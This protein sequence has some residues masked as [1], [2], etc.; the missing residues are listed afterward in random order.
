MSRWSCEANQ[1]GPPL[2]NEG[3]TRTRAT[4]CRHRSTWVFFQPIFNSTENFCLTKTVGIGN[5]WFHQSPSHVPLPDSL[6]IW[7]CTIY[8]ERYIVYLTSSAFLYFEPPSLVSFY[9]ASRHLRFTFHLQGYN[10]LENIVSLRIVLTCSCL[11]SWVL[12]LLFLSGV[13]LRVHSCVLSS[14]TL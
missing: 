1:G 8:L 4:R 9:W 7:P 13:A 6:S 11:H 12:F 5:L 10:I 14:V 3:C 2:Q